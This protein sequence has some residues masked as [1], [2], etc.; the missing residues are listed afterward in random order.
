[1]SLFD[2]LLISVTTFFRDPAAWEA[3]R[4]QVVVPLVERAE[5]NQPIRIWVP[6]CA[7]GEEAYTL[8]ILFREEISRRDVHCDIVIFGSDVDQGALVTARE[9]VY[10]A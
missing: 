5:A 3:L 6:G 10:P 9:G 4:L 7:S 8:A 2:D 1:Q